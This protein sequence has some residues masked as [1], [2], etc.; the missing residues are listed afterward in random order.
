MSATA[1]PRPRGP[2]VVVS[3]RGCG[4]SIVAQSRRRRWCSQRCR[5]RT[6]YTGT[7]GRCGGETYNGTASPPELCCHCAPKRRTK[8]T[9]ERVIERIRRWAELHGEPPAAHEWAPAPSVRARYPGAAWKEIERRLAAGQWP[10]VNA[11]QAVFGS[12]SAGLQAAGFECSWGRKRGVRVRFSERELLEGLR[13][14]ACAHGAAPTVREWVAGGA[15]PSASTLRHRFGSWNAA[16]AKAGL[17]GRT[18][19]THLADEELVEALRRRVA[20]SGTVPTLGEW[21]VAGA[22]PSDSTFRRRFGSWRGALRAA[23]LD[24]R[25]AVP[26]CGS[27]KGGARRRAATTERADA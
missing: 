27:H 8:W 4:E 25:A 21:R 16:L 22:G 23:G 15:S 13:A 14:W 20:E 10:S 18:A 26:A 9:A 1:L 7:C 19:R 11:V 17:G 24:G 2:A 3:C 12:W 5:K 6:L